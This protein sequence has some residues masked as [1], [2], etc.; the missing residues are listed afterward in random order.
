[1]KVLIIN[2]PR[3]EG[4][5]VTREGRCELVM[6]YRVDT[7]AT[8]LIIASILRNDNHSIKFFD[9]NGLNLSYDDLLKL[10]NLMKFDCLIFTFNSQ[11]IDHDLRIC[12]IIKRINPACITIGYSWYARKFGKE[13]L[14]EYNNLDILIVD[15]LFSIIEYLIKCLDNNNDLSKV[16]GITYRNNKNEIILNEKVIFRKKLDELPLPAYDLL[17]SFKQYYLYSPLLSPYA[18]VYSGKGCPF[19]CIYCNVA[20]TNYSGKSAE[21]VILELKT[22]KKLGKV[23]YVWFFDEIFTL[24]RRRTIEICKRIIKERLKIKWFCDSRVDLVDQELLKIMRKAGCIGISY[25][26]ES[27]SNKI[28]NLMNKKI[29]IEQAKKALSWTRQVNIPIQLNL[30]IGYIG[31]TKTTLKETENFIRE[32]LPDF[33]QVS[34]MQALESTEFI[35]IALK[36]NWISRDM[37]WKTKLIS[38]HKKLRNY[39]PYELNLWELRENFPKMLF[40]NL[41]W[42][43]YSI[44]TLMR[45]LCLIKPIFYTFLRKSQTISL[46]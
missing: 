25:G 19:G 8:L 37:D 40:Y 20:N 17:R 28:L 34:V 22:L 42:W 43:I 10:F 12:S 35:K 21:K 26:V 38:P 15:D 31:E 5:S 23:K 27:G 14:N 3:Y 9:A 13:I 6:D 16:N 33:I 45:N 44:K 4:S 41:K 7:P 36:N 11:I 30:L 1:M 46:I 18:L 29:T 2:P 32:T 24:N 39:K